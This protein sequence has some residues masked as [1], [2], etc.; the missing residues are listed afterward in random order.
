M[1]AP[2]RRAADRPSRPAP[3][4]A[5]VGLV[6]CAVKVS[7]SLARRLRKAAELEAA[8]SS[9]RDALLAAAGLS[10]AQLDEQ[11]RQVEELGAERD[12]LRQRLADEQSEVERLRA[13]AKQ[14]EGELT[15]LRREGGNASNELGAARRQLA[16]AEKQQGEARASLAGLRDELARSVSIA[17]LNAEA[18][19]A[20]GAL[21]EN[22]R[23]G[24][25]LVGAALRLTGYEES[26]V[27]AALETRRRPEHQAL[28]TA[29]QG[30]SWRAWLLRRLLGGGA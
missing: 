24:A 8:G 11:A 3:P 21:T 9:P 30:G 6:E 2:V 16:A 17:G 5:A 1:S 20:V 12:A 25:G 7:P 13:A 18:V 28:D 26:E 4:P 14:R 10:G 22:L 19:A 15:R 23:S 29:L 27:R